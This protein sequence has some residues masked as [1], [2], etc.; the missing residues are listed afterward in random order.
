ML[1][2]R[3]HGTLPNDFRKY[4]VAHELARFLDTSHFASKIRVPL[5]NDT[6]DVARRDLRHTEPLV[7]HLRLR[8]LAGSRSADQDQDLS[9]I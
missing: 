1:T 6:Q 4:L 9:S 3:K 5:G 7:E 8:A 2:V